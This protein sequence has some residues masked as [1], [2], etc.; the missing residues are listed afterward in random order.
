ML[1]TIVD[2]QYCMIISSPACEISLFARA[3]GQV[4][5]QGI[6]VYVSVYLGQFEI[7]VDM[8]FRPEEWTGAHRFGLATLF[9]VN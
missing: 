8:A 2:I 7:K 1:Y 5:R 4:R 9:H 3:L 6:L